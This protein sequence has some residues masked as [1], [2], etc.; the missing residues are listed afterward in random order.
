MQKEIT[1][2]I[3]N[4]K[5]KI[6]GA[7][8]SINK[9]PKEITLIAV[10][11]K[12]SVQMIETALES[13]VSCFGENYAQ[14]LQEKSSIIKSN[15]I[16]WHF[17]GPIQS[18]KIK[19]IANNAN[20]VHT[21]DREKVIKKLNLE[22]EQINKT[23]EAC[24]QVNISSELSKS[25]CRPENL[26]AIAKIVESMK[27]INLRGIMA[28]PKLTDT[29]IEREETMKLILNLSK[30]LQSSFPSANAI[31]LGTTSD[32]EDAI[33]HGSTM[34]RIGESIFGKRL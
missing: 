31:S 33:I 17:I 7:C 5:N 27:N 18:N 24:I 26:L 28:L 21:L 19:I 32:F 8:A 2:N 22:C 15:K 1:K 20:W 11:K 14:E 3:E 13:G 30:K 6:S 29:K 16:I 10:S 4:I 12:K 25:G 23:I 34:V 9:D